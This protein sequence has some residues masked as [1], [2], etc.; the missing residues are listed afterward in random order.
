MFSGLDRETRRRL[1]ER[2]IDIDKSLRL[3]L[4]E[5]RVSP[6]PMLLHDLGLLPVLSERDINKEAWSSRWGR[7]A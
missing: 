2:G 3:L 7:A 6:P 5:V 4:A 1:E